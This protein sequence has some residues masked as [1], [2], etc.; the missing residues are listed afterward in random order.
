MAIGC[1]RLGARPGLRQL[2]R[3]CIYARQS[4]NTK[5]FYVLEDWRLGNYSIHRL[6]R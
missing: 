4:L 5:N 1:N 2:T 3:P 6:R